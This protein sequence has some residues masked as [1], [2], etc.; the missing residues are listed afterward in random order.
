MFLWT[1]HMVHYP[2]NQHYL[3]IQFMHSGFIPLKARKQQ[4]SVLLVCKNIRAPHKWDLLTHL[5]NRLNP[6]EHFT[7]SIKTQHFYF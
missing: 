6:E 1:Q 4:N 2:I 3:M 5:Y 7:F